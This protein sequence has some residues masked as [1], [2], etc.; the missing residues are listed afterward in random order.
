MENDVFFVWK[1]GVNLGEAILIRKPDI[2]FV[3]AVAFEN[4][5]IGDKP[6]AGSLW[7]HGINP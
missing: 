2:C 1:K 4:R 3:A 6:S 7:I 5:V